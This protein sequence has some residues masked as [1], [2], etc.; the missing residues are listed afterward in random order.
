[1]SDIQSIDWNSFYEYRDGDLYWKVDSGKNKLKGKLAGG[2]AP[3]G[4]RSVCAQGTACYAHRVVWEMH[5]GQIA[6]NM[7][8]HHING[9]RDDNRIENLEMVTHQ[10][11]L[12]L[13]ESKGYHY[14]KK[15]GKYYSTI[16]VDGSVPQWLGS[17]DTPEEA[18]KAYVEAKAKYHGVVL[19]V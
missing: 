18:R 3:S 19:D 16:R 7:E 1:M 17:F 11:N 4:Y 9:N 5:N 15:S 12:H 2:L 14:N 10:R 8:I 6:D 13:K